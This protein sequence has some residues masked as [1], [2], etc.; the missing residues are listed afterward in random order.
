M[1]PPSP[2]AAAVARKQQRA[3]LVA[4]LSRTLDELRRLKTDHN[5]AH[6]ATRKGRYLPVI[7]YAQLKL[8][9][10]NLKGKSRRLQNAIRELKGP[11]KPPLP[12]PPKVQPLDPFETRAAAP[13]GASQKESAQQGKWREMTP[14]K[15]T[16]PSGA[17]FWIPLKLTVENWSRAR[18]RDDRHAS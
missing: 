14:A 11:R 3:A 8:N 9:V 16:S 2:P 10:E 1:Q 13:R 17:S 6:V 4:E 15:P 7:Q 5:R 12:V 18:F